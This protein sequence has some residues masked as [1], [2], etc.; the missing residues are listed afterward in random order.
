MIYIA[1]P[2][3]KEAEVKR[4][5]HLESLLTTLGLEFFSP[6]LESNLKFE[7]GKHEEC[8][9]LNI[10]KLK[11]ADKV[12]VITNGKDVGTLFEAGVAFA[13]GKEVY[14]LFLGGKK[15]NLM[16]GFSGVAI[17]TFANL[18]K[19][20]TSQYSYNYLKRTSLEGKKFF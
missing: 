15:F 17:T 19:A 9:N 3:F 11:E 6:R 2:F 16:L 20:L 7:E 13:L 18:K 5:K 8:F 14:Y 10:E 1:A 12:I 4:V